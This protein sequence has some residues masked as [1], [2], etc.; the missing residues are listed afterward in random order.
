[1]SYSGQGLRESQ[2]QDQSVNIAL[3]PL[4]LNK[5][6]LLAI[7]KVTTPFD[8][9]FYGCTNQTKYEMIRHFWVLV[10]RG[11]GRLAI[12]LLFQE[13]IE[14]LAS[15]SMTKL[16]GPARAQP[17]QVERASTKHGVF[18]SG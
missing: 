3:P 15:L 6:F 4:P 14:G 5:F 18:P 12:S 10:E 13:A 17:W 11:T 2:G 1:M 16:L 8:L 9:K 7:C